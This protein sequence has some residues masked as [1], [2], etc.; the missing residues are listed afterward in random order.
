[1]GPGQQHRHPDGEAQQELV[2][3]I[4]TQL[5]LAA[6][7]AALESKRPSP[8]C[9]YHADRECQYASET[10]RRALRDAGLP[11]SR[12]SPANPY[13]NAQV[14]SFMKTHKVEQ[15][16]LAGARPLRNAATGLPRFIE[17]VYHAKR[18]HSAGGYPSLNE[19][20]LQLAR[21][22]LSSDGPVVQPEG[23]TPNSDQT[24]TEVNTSRVPVNDAARVSCTSLPSFNALDLSTKCLPPPASSCL[25]A[26][27]F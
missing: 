17:E 2:N 15:L 8:G 22:S 12:S 5:A 25:A 14:G 19:F 26:A 18:P 16:Y 27:T 21:E 7:R 13:D 1:M 9:I 24:A 4:D 3:K 23:F 20:K 10:Y 6:L 11:G